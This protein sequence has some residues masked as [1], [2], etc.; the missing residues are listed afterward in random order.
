MYR[1]SQFAI[2]KVLKNLKSYEQNHEGFINKDGEV[3]KVSSPSVFF[4]QLFCNLNGKS[5]N[6]VV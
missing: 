3:K 4:V 1:N 2:E 5:K 6:T